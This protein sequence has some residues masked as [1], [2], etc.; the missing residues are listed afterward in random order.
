[1]IVIQELQNVELEC[2]L[3]ARANEQP[4]VS[5]VVSSILQEVKSTGDKA[6]LRFTQEFDSADLQSLRVSEAEIE[7]A[8][9]SVGSAFFSILQEAAE[10]IKAFHQKQVRQGFVMAER[11]GVVAGQKIT[12]LACVGIYVPGGT[13]AYPSTVLMD[14]IPAQIAGVENIV[15]VTPPAQDGKIPAGV[16]A[17]AKVAG[18]SSVYKCGGAQAVAA[19]AYGTESIP[20]VDK[21][22]GPGNIFVAT[23]KRMVYGLVDIDMIAGPSDVLVVA[24]ESAD[25]AFVA[26]DMLAQAE[27][28]VHASAVLVTT[29]PALA[30]NVQK[31]IEEQM[32]R[33]PRAEI[34]EKSIRKNGMILLA[35]NITEA[36]KAVNSIAPEHLELCVRD[37]FALLPL[38]E[39]AGSIFLGHTTPEA[40]GDYFAGPNHTLPTGGTARFS[41]PL[42]VDDFIKKSSYLYYS[43]EALSAVASKVQL[44]AQSEGLDAHANSVAVRVSRKKQQ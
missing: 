11:P 30:E 29:S 35:Q 10:N 12:P 27:H 26:A 41:S 40:L 42:S 2:L 17:A 18:V 23:A 16:L 15:M 14:A 39:N 38:V 3:A 36:L 20:K 7:E 32:L 8:C 25:P 4:D 33:L 43:A 19:L 22:V 28:D 21:I 34:V 5:Q 13:A 37:P 44:F 24:D 1:M 31:E 6:V 9:H